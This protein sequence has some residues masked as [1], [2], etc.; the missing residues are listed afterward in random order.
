MNEASARDT[1]LRSF[2][3]HLAASA[4]FHAEDRLQKHVV[5]KEKL[6][7]SLKADSSE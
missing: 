5:T 7:S 4:M 1:A 2:E 6:T 3:A